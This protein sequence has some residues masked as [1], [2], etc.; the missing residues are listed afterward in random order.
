MPR[1]RPKVVDPFVG[2]I[3]D[4]PVKPG[5]I[6]GFRAVCG[7]LAS[8]AFLLACGD[9]ASD[10]PS[11]G[12]LSAE[13]VPGTA[14]VFDIGAEIE[15]PDSFFDMP[16]PSDLRRTSD[17]R[18]RLEGYPGAAGN[19]VV[20]P[21]LRA[22]AQRRGFPVNPAA[23]FRFDGPVAAQELGRVWP[24][25][26]ESPV[27]LLDVD[28]TSAERGRRFPVVAET[29][30]AD[31]FTPDFALSLSVPPGV[32]LA[33]ERTYAF[34]VSRSLADADGEL[35]GVGE[36]FARLRA[37][38]PLAGERG[39]DVAEA[40]RPLWETLDSIGV[41]RREIAAA[42]VF[43]TGDVVGDAAAWIDELAP[44]LPVDVRDL[45]VTPDGG[46]EH[47]RFCQLSGVVEMPQLQRGVP[48]YDQ[49]GD[50]EIG[51][52]G[53][54]VVQRYESVP[55]TLTLPRTPMPAGGYPFVLYVHGSGGQADQVVHRGPVL[56]PGG[57]RERGQGPAHVYAAHGIASAA[58][59]M[60]LN[61]ERLPGAAS[62]AYLNL[63]NL[64]AYPF[65]FQQGTF[66]Q[67]LFLDALER[68]E[69]DEGTVAACAGVGGEGPIRLNVGRIGMHGQSMGAQYANMLAAVDPRVE[70]VLPTGSGGLWTLVIL[71]A[72]IEG[73]LDVGTVIGP[74]L[75]AQEPVTYLHPGL[76][77][78]QLALEPAETMVFADRIGHRPLAGH[79]ARHM[80]QPVGQ[81][82]P[83][84]PVQI[85]DAMALA[86][87]NQQAGESLWP[88]LQESL[89]LA[90]LDGA[91]AYPAR[92]N[93]TSLDG[94]SRTA[95][96]A[97]YE[98]D[99]ILDGHHI[100]AQRD[101]VKH[102]YGCF[103]E[104]FFRDGVPTLPG[105]GPLGSACP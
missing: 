58:T 14:L 90:G 49:D 97:A 67:R 75:G 101:D 42:T 89:A 84:F 25:T 34:V 68:L 45:T 11:G 55:V 15:D 79:P 95:V 100:F 60:P 104:S 73:G 91:V 9:D 94:R 61:P 88:S 39:R 96:V 8:A 18:P 32:V 62:R 33:P 64:G 52:D 48:P 77:L 23:I 87:A 51:S 37:E 27:Q 36:D 59:A 41:D 78:V 98:P 56:V 92:E 4:R 13:A 26:A 63:L 3:Q 30:G 38:A 28:P 103:F 72:T 76:Q 19:G 102:Q 74:L 82:D 71:L 43:T 31:P 65:T 47:E 2:S 16:W 40:Y 50:F 22:A 105:P 53:L 81:D 93:Q 24:A 10:G 85:Y 21:V 86:S 7:V 44:R 1:P 5:M 35:L 12:E 6:A 54:P 70:A 99:G 66:E 69:I 17:G 20:S 57:D 83:G 46:A 29:R 80:F